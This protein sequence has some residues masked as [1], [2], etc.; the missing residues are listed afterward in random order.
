[1]LGYPSEEIF[2]G[3]GFDDVFDVLIQSWSAHEEWMS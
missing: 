2:E 3:V 1:M